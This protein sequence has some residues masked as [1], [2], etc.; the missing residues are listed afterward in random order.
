MDWAK[1]ILAA[2]GYGYED[3][4]NILVNLEKSDSEL[5]KDV[6]ANRRNKINRARK[7]GLQFRLL[8]DEHALTQAYA[9]LKDVYRRA[10]MP[11]PDLSLF[12]NL[13]DLPGKENPLRLFAA[14]DKENIA[15]IMIALC[16]RERIYEWYVGGEQKYFDKYPNDMIPWEVFLW[17]KSHGYK[18]FDFGGAGKPGVPYGVRD[19]KLK[20]GGELV[21]FGRFQKVHNPLTMT[22]AKLGFRLWQFLKK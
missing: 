8:S 5:W 10:R 17:G 21:N 19:F 6:H 22:V 3:H 18:V 20:F 9:V 16:Y 12:K 11:L 13:N 7:N 4:L 15:G 1:S 2:K 14:F